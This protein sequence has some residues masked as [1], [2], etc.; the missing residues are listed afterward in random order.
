M[1]C[2]KALTSWGPH[3]FPG[4]TV[5]VWEPQGGATDGGLL[6]RDGTGNGVWTHCWGAWFILRCGEGV[7]MGVKSLLSLLRNRAVFWLKTVF[8]VSVFIWLFFVF[9]CLCLADHQGG[10]GLQLPPDSWAD[11]SLDDKTHKSVSQS[12]QSRPKDALNSEKGL[13]SAHFPKFPPN[14]WLCCCCS[15]TQLCPTLCDTLNCSNPGLPVSHHLPEFSQVHVHWIDDA[16]QA[17]HPL[18]P[19]SPFAFNLSQ[20]HGLFQWVCCLHQ[21]AKVLSFSISPFNEYSG[22]ISW[23]LGS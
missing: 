1:L 21:V 9:A 15:G 5:P 22:L 12:E 4:E 18:L 2:G 6:S 3:W 23:L 17:S 20:H 10:W 11:V 13:Q 19:S 8:F 14:L 7:D 16:I